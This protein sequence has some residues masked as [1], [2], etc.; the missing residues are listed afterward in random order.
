MITEQRVIMPLVGSSRCDD[1]TP[2]RGVPTIKPIAIAAAC[3]RKWKSDVPF[4]DDL[5]AYHLDP[6]GVVISTPTIF[7]MAKV[8][9][10]N[11]PA[12]FVRVAVG[13]LTE[14]L[15]ATPAWLDKICFCRRND[16]R[17]R[18]YPLRRLI[19][20]ASTLQPFNPSTKETDNGRIA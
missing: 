15:R 2:Q 17:L 8:I 9:D 20:L 13:N 10:M 1:R 4:I 3:Y 11:G 6:H 5:D 19:K 7:A 18:V 16:G 14:L 12:W